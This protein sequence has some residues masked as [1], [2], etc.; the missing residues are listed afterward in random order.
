MYNVYIAEKHAMTFSK[1][2]ESDISIRFLK[3]VETQKFYQ[4]C[5]VKKF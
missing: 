4:Y 5:V 2:V 1:V 3:T